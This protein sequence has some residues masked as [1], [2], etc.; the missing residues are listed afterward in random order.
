LLSTKNVIALPVVP[1][2]LLTVKEASLLLGVS[3]SWVR[4]HVTELP[5]VRVGLLGHASVKTT[6]DIYG[7][8]LQEDFEVPLAEM[9][10][11]LLPDVAQKRE[12]QVAA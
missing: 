8:V 3:E 1:P 10:A 9:A 5:T 12:I 6:L 11:K 4:R 7:H 2:A